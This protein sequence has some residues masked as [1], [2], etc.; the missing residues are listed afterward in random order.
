[1]KEIEANRSDWIIEVLIEAVK[2]SAQKELSTVLPIVSRNLTAMKE[3]LGER[4]KFSA[5]IMAIEGAASSTVN[6]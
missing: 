3:E 4:Q 1:M 2:L 5:L 6:R